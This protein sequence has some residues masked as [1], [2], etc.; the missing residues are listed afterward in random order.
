MPA[1]RD[2]LVEIEQLDPSRLCRQYLSADDMADA[3]DEI[4]GL[5]R[6]GRLTVMLW[7][8]LTLP[9][10]PA[11]LG[12]RVDDVERLVVLAADLW[13]MVHRSPGPATTLAPSPPSDPAFGQ[14]LDLA[15]ADGCPV[16][17]S[18]LGPAVGGYC[19]RSSEAPGIV[20]APGADAVVLA[21][22]LGHWFDPRPFTSTSLTEREQFADQLGAVLLADGTS[23][24]AR[25]RVLAG[26]LVAGRVDDGA[27][28]DS[29]G[30]GLQVRLLDWLERVD[31]LVDWG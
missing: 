11:H 6:T 4:D 2:L 18:D 30:P 5:H 31:Q 3:C 22:E 25:A 15:T 27:T 26:R 10:M 13:R 29:T 24:P 7:L 8:W 1:D 21:H 9:G 16:S 19:S 17:W 28:L 20:L 23:D 14:L 12:A